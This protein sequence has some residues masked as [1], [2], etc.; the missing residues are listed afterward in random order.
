IYAITPG[1]PFLKQEF[2]FLYSLERWAREGM[3]AD[4]PREKL[5]D[6]DDCGRF[7]IGNLGWCEAAFQPSFEDK[8][9][10]DRGEYEVVQDTAGRH[11]LCFKGRRSGFMPEYLD[12]PVKDRKTWENNV[13]WRLDPETPQR[14]K[15]LDEYL[16]KAQVAA[17][18]GLMIT[19]LVVGAYMYLRSLMGPEQVL[20]AFYDM[21]DVIHDCMRSWLKLAD[22]V[23]ARHQQVVTLDEIFFGEDI[24][25]NHGSL[26]SPDLMKE[27]L[28]PYYQQLVQNTRARQ[29]DRTRHLYVHIDTDGHAEPV[30]PLYQEA[31]GMD[32]MS[33]FEVASG[34]DVVKIGQKYPHL[35]MTGGIDKRIIAQG[36]P[37]IDRHLE[38][39]LPAMRRRGGYYPTCDHAVPEEVSYQNY[40]YY[41]KR[42]VELGG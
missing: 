25:Y 36:P 35:V 19:Q 15:D 21:P 22:A 23:I 28:F 12:H 38:A 40:L 29:L 7:S 10:E 13:K 3:S 1:A 33:P 20:Y 2:G 6:F 27:F 32:V 37:A 9:L 30:I 18:Q 24:C 26:I 41:R 8:I 5:F 11:V 4:V 31:I 42:C 34:C 16:G 17:S 39:I 14:F